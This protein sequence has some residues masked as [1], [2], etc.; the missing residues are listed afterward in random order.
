MSSEQKQKLNPFPEAVHFDSLP[1]AVQRFPGQTCKMAFHPRPENLTE[2]N[3]GLVRYEPGAWHPLHSHDFAQVWYILE[4]EFF[5]GDNKYG[6]GT[7]LFHG[8]PHTE[9]ALRTD[10]GGVIIYVQYPGPNTG[11]API[12][13]GR[14]NLEERRP[15]EEERTDI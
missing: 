4:G 14:F 5:Y 2:P 8:D 13:D 1:W 15:V 11:K 7:M 10:T 12:Y 9:P 6:P 3:A